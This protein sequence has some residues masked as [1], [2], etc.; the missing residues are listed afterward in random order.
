MATVTVTGASGFLGAH[1]IKYTEKNHPDWKLVA[2]VRSTPLGFGGPNI[3]CLTADLTKPVSAQMMA[4]TNPD[5]IV[6]FAAAITEDDSREINARMMENV[7]EACRLSGAKLIFISSSQVNFARLNQYAKSKIDDEKAAM[8][9]GIP[10]VS[11]R[12]AAPYGALLPDHKA[13]RDQSMHALVK[14]INKLPAIPV[15]GDGR[16][17]RQPLYVDD[18]NHAI[19]WFIVNDRF[20]NE[21]YDIGGPRAIP[22]DDITDILCG[23]VGKQVMKVHL[24]KA[25]F[26]FSTNFIGLF[27]R[28]LLQTVDTDETANN[29]PILELLGKESFTPFEQ[30]AQSLV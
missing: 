17:T 18:F 21:A 9:S 30:G 29:G 10:H 5:I 16:Y 26:I 19:N 4:S 24:P 14:F 23:L 1:Y 13:A 11:L 8:E 20:E 12:P 15:I 3:S 22:L 28:D 6:H 2:Q 25:L 7:L 27:N